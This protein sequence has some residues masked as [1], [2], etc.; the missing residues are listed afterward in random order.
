MSA[1]TTNYFFVYAPD[2][3]EEGTLALRLSV[4]PSH[5]EGIKDQIAAG[6]VRS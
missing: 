1:T 6:T 4:R 3:T 5:Y 2:K